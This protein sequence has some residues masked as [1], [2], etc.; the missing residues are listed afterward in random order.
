MTPHDQEARELV[1]QKNDS[2]PKPYDFDNIT[3]KY[4]ILEQS[5]ESVCGYDERVKV[6]ATTV[7]PYKAIC[8]LYM[9]A[10]NGKNFIGTGWLTHSNKLYTAGHCVYDDKEGGW[11]KSII[12]VPGMSG[13]TEPYGRYTSADM[14]TTKGWLNNSSR[15]YDMGAIKLSSNVSHTDFIIPTLADANAA[16]ICGYPKDRD[17]G[18]FQYKMQDSIS[19]RNDRFFYQIDTFGGQSGAPVLQNNSRAIGIHNY[20]G[21][22]NSASDLYAEFVDGINDW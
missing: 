14:I 21:C 11:M 20:G 17:T 4:F 10:A 2:D 13:G 22:D 5:Q 8:K 1:F 9:K 16:T 3:P 15:R 7:L 6:T 18:I 19:K 12:I